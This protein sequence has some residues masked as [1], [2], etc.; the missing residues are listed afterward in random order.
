MRK[1]N[2]YINEQ[3]C[4]DKKV[5]TALLNVKSKRPQLD[6][7]IILEHALEAEPDGIPNSLYLDLLINRGIEVRWKKAQW[8]G[9]IPQKNHS[10]T[11]SVD[12]KFV[13]VGSAN[14]DAMTMF[15]SFRDQQVDIFDPHTTNEHDAVFLRWWHNVDPR[16]EYPLSRNQFEAYDYET[17]QVQPFAFLVPDFFVDFEGKPLQAKNFLRVG[18]GIVKLLYDYVVL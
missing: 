14:K 12:G 15:G 3:F 8:I 2:I 5:I 9:N 11:L 1:K 10:K 16:T 7:K 13:I 6:I 18:R 17:E 4:F